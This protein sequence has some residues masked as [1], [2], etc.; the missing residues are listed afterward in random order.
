MP[1]PFDI[2]IRNGQVVNADGSVHL[3]VG[4]RG[5]KIVALSAAIEDAGETEIDA[6]KRL[7]FPG[8]IDGHTHMGIPIMGTHS[9]DDFESGSVAAACGGITTIVDFTVQQ[10]GEALHESVKERLDKADSKSHVDYALHVN[11]TDQPHKRL[12]EI[13]ELIRSGYSAF[14]VFST[15]RE[16][17]MMITWPEFRAVLDVVHRNGG[18]LFLHAEDNALIE[19]QT[20]QNVTAGHKAAI[21]HA[22]SR[23]SEAEAKAIAAAAQIAR[24]LDARL[25]IVHLSSR[26]GLEAALEARALGAKLILETCPQYLVLTEE[27][28]EQ[29]NGHYWITTPALR[30]QED[31][32][33]LWQAVAG[34]DI[35]VVATDHCPFTVEQKNAAMGTFH[36]TPNGLPG[37][38]T[39]FPLLYSYGVARGRISQERLVELLATA[40]ARYLGLDERKGTIQPGADADI[41]VWNPNTPWQIQAPLMHGKADWS[42]YEGMDISGRVEHVFLRGQP[43]VTDTEFVGQQIQGRCLHRKQ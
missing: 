41:V 28:Y 24:E 42:P 23:T 1:Q 4:I 34:G 12:V 36:L 11:V 27:K 20:A 38:E 21:Y 31:T 37:V 13:P 7:V 10:P 9:I 5:S 14:K 40:P 29:R 6:A 39:L 18:L 43:L 8:F 26:A 32:E 35:D 22:R 30:T 3:D 33:A 15:Y 17:G 25:Y 16:A 2:I 19:A